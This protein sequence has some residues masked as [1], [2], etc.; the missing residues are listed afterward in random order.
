MRSAGRRERPYV[1]EGRV[2]MDTAEACSGRCATADPPGAR[3][4]EE[5]TGV[6]T[7]KTFLPSLSASG[8]RVGYVP[9]KQAVHSSPRSCR[10]AA[11]IPSSEM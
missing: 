9:E 10:V 2:S 3:R 8:S 11:I 1:A 7:S 4:G 6:R 5:S